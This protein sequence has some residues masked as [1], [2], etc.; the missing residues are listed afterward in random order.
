MLGVSICSRVILSEAVC[1][2][3]WGAILTRVDLRNRGG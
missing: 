3:V 2:D 1:V